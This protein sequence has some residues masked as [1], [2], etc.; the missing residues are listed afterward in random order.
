MPRL[1]IRNGMVVDGAGNPWFKSDL[2]VMGR[3]ISRIGKISGSKAKVVD[4]SGCI[5][6]PGFIDIHSH[7]DLDI[8]VNPKAESKVRQGVTTE[9]FPNLSLIHI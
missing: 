7:S 4:A 3:K 1:V 2:Q 9:V 6:A 5:V 8:L